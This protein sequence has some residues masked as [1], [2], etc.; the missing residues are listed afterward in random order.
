MFLRKVCG[1]AGWRSFVALLF[2]V[3]SAA[4]AAQSVETGKLFEEY[5]GKAFQAIQRIPFGIER[6]IAE[7]NFCEINASER[8]SKAE[9]KRV[10]LQEVFSHVQQ[11][12]V[13][14]LD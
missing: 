1:R 11:V 6:V 8:S 2:F 9:E 13:T 5:S 4:F 14:Q 7:V 12:D 3:S 10:L